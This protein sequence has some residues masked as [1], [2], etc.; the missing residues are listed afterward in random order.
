MTSAR[1][2]C[3]ARADKRPNFLPLSCNPHPAC[4]APPK[5]GD[6]DILTS[7]L[8]RGLS[9]DAVV[10]ESEREGGGRKKGYRSKKP[11]CFLMGYLFFLP[12]LFSILCESLGSVTME[13]VSTI[14]PE[15]SVFI[16]G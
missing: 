7:Q 12:A 6:G 1:K 4:S 5:S 10:Q 16:G 2:S 9:S 14:G 8:V 13:I 11:P 15:R 3:I